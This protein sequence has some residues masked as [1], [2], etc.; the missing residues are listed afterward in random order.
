MATE[1]KEENTDNTK[2]EVK[3]EQPKEETV[4]FEV[5]KTRIWQ[6]VAV[7]LLLAMIVFFVFNQ[8]DRVQP[9]AP[10]EQQRTDP[11]EVS[12]DDDPMLGNK[13]APVTI[14][15]FEDFQCPFCGRAFQQTFPLLKQEYI[16]TGK[17]RYVFRDFPLI[18]IHPNAQPASE[19]AECAHEQ[20]KFWQ[21]HEGLFLNQQLLGR[22]FYLSLAEQN[23]L[24]IG[25][26]TQCIDTRKYQ[27]EVE[28]DLKYGSSLGI[29]GT[30]TF[31]ISGN[32]LVGAQPYEAFKQ[33]IEGELQ[34]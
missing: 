10:T 32:R 21:F 22:D 11:I 30:P 23:G 15:S 4:K 31:F 26:F 12:I 1:N 9:I 13:D 19:A 8:D 33:I 29:T 6:G 28:N 27:S 34:E 18:S 25:Q 16:D 14:V 7:V 3:E 5:A 17:V 24:D 2:E 20:D